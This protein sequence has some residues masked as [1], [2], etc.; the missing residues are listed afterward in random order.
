MERRIKFGLNVF[1]LLGI[2][3]SVM[4]GI[5]TAVGLMLGQSIPGEDGRVLGIVFP[6]VGI[7]FLLVGLG[8]WGME[9]RKRAQIRRLVRSGDFIWGHVSRIDW[10]TMVTINHRHPNVAVVCC[11]YGGQT[12]FF[13]SRH[14]PRH[15]PEDLVGKQ[16]RVYCQPPK[17]KPYYVD[18]EPLLQNLVIH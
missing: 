17:C 16:V 3:F 6:C 18:M 4:G 10:D 1:L 2:T 13:T 7:P 15:F 8:F 5:F 14:L 12:H 9:L 11:Q